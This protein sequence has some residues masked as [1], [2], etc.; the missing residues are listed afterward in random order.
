[1]VHHNYQD[2]DGSG[3]LDQAEFVK[4]MRELNVE[5]NL[6]SLNDKALK[7]LFSYFGTCCIQCVVCLVDLTSVCPIFCHDL[8]KTKTIPDLFLTMSSWW[9]SG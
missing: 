1:M 7:H 2:D 6:T 3:T 5:F 8:L 9:E 4:G